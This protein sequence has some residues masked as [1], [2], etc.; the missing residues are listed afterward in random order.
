MEGSHVRGGFGAPSIQCSIGH[1]PPCHS[2]LSNRGTLLVIFAIGHDIF[3][4][5]VAQIQLNRAGRLG[6]QAAVQFD[7]WGSIAKLWETVAQLPVW[8]GLE[9]LSY[10]PF[11]LKGRLVQQ[12]LHWPRIQEH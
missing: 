10:L 4:Q 5:G 11:Q 12:D 9:G 8:V 1:T 2:T 7:P 3:P 6:P